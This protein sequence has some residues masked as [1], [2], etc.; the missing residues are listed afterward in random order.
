[1]YLG[2]SLLESSNASQPDDEHRRSPVMTP[3]WKLWCRS[4]FPLGSGL[5]CSSTVRGCEVDIVL[6]IRRQ[7]IQMAFVLL[8]SSGTR[9][10]ILVPPNSIATASE[11]LE[12]GQEEGQGGG[13]CEEKSRQGS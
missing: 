4:D 12:A 1:M 8:C 13:A 5:G 10:R 7:L 9:P 11:D 2:I 3:W 6:V